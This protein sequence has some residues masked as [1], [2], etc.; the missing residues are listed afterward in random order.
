MVDSPEGKT[1]LGLVNRLEPMAKELGA[2][3]AQ[4]ALAWCLVNP[5]VSSVITGASR[6]E[7]VTENMKALEI[8]PRL[9][10]RAMERIEEILGN[11][12]L[13]EE[14]ARD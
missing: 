8:V 4:L 10:T 2:T 11:R 5:N 14:D 12:P 1:R 6:P 3:M 9:D 13:A 7:Q